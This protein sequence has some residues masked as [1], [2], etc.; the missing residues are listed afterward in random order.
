MF[1][2]ILS[3]GTV[4]DLFFELVE[5]INYTPVWRYDVTHTHLFTCRFQAACV[6]SSIM[7]DSTRQTKL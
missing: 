6:P 7:F 3:G 1:P 5:L 2:V 4:T